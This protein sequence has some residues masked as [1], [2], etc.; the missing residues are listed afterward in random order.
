MIKFHVV[1]VKYIA[2]FLLMLLAPIYFSCTGLHQAKPHFGI[3]NKAMQDEIAV[4][5][6]SKI[7]DIYRRP[8]VTI[9]KKGV[10][11]SEVTKSRFVMLPPGEYA[12][13]IASLNRK[14]KTVINSG[15]TKLTITRP[16]YHKIHLTAQAGKKYRFFGTGS[17]VYEKFIV[18]EVIDKTN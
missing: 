12:F 18:K 3:S 8:S 11:D 17:S 1:A 13:L 9:Y 16:Y 5:D 4:V 14:E 10:P 15:N 6:L 2:F 7:I